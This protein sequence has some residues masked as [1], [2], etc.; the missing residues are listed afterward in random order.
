MR[1]H[2][3]IGEYIRGREPSTSSAWLDS[4]ACARFDLYFEEKKL[5]YTFHYQIHQNLI[6]HKL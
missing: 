1:A 3:L 6:F 2:R 4:A 5:W